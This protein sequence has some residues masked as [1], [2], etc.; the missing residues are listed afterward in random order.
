MATLRPKLGE[1]IEPSRFSTNSTSQG[2]LISEQNPVD[3]IRLSDE[4]RRQD[5]I[6]T[7]Q[8]LE[9]I[10]NI[11]ARLQKLQHL[12]PIARAHIEIVN[13]RVFFYDNYNLELNVLG[14]VALRLQFISEFPKDINYQPVV[15]QND[16]V[17]HFWVVVDTQEQNEFSIQKYDTSGIAQTLNTG[18]HKLHIV[19]FGTTLKAR[20]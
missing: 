8:D 16:N 13:N 9:N 11:L 20:F 18:T 19:V 2:V 5:V 4:K 12:I 7:A 6:D 14:T 1:L 3:L 10:E 17:P 15:I